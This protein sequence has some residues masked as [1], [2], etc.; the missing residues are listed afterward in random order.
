M[1]VGH[2]VLWATRDCLSGEVLLARSLFSGGTDDLAPLLRDP[3]LFNCYVVPGLPR[4]NDDLE[5]QFGSQHYHA[6]RATG[7]KAALF[8]AVLRGEVGLS[9]HT[10]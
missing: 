8:A 10:P 1:N 5:Q 3:G 7:L 6:R 4:T 2:E 9:A